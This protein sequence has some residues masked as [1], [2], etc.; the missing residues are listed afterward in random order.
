MGGL[1]VVEIHPAVEGRAVLS[2]AHV[3]EE[4][5]DGAPLLRLLALLPRLVR[6]GAS[7]QI[8]TPSARTD[9]APRD[10]SL[11]AIRK[12]PLIVKPER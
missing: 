10:T 3:L 7:A 12:P 4:G 2:S 5:A 11:E 1:K 9:A 8:D 6:H